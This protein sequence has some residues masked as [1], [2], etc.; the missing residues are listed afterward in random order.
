MTKFQVGDLIEGTAAANFRYSITRQGWRG[1]VTAVS[2]DGRRID[3]KAED[4]LNMEFHELIARC[5]KLIERPAAGTDTTVVIRHDGATTTAVL[6]RGRETVR[7]ATAKCSPE[8]TFDAYTGA[9]TA[10]ARLFGREVP[11]A[12]DEKAKPFPRDMLTDGVFVRVGSSEWA[13][14][15]DG[16]LVYE[17]G[18][19]D[20]LKNVQ[21]D[22]SLGSL[23]RKIM[24][25][26]HALSFDHARMYADIH[27]PTKPGAIGLI[28]ACPDDDKKK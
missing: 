16:R 14:V 17:N 15:A 28:W 4:C 7:T 24:Y 5:F 9:S 8:D 18:G 11:T 20:R 26:V 25:I 27:P 23:G 21:A 3:A 22:G 13:V 19:W 2:D 10:L 12:V 1:R 6:R